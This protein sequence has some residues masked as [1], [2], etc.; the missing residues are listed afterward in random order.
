[1]YHRPT[2]SV[3]LVLT[4]IKREHL[5]NLSRMIEVSA[6]ADN[7]YTAVEGVGRIGILCHVYFEG[8]C[9][10]RREP[11]WVILNKSELNPRADKV[12]CLLATIFQL[13]FRKL[14]NNIPLLNSCVA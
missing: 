6:Q 3:Y 11:L 12:R 4:P 1:M 9:E 8:S 13:T 14:F 5:S 7:R 2:R 10:G